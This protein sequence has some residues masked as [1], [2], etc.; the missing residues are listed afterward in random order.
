MS[1]DLLNTFDIAGR[2]SFSTAVHIYVGK[3]CGS[4]TTILWFRS[5]SWLSRW[6]S[7]HLS[8]FPHPI[9]ILSQYFQANSTWISVSSSYRSA[10]QLM[11]PQNERTTR[12]SKKLMLHTYLSFCHLV[13]Y[14]WIN[15]NYS[16]FADTVIHSLYKLIAY[17]RTA[18]PFRAAS[19]KRPRKKPRNLDEF[20]TIAWQRLK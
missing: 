16:H 14:K 2:N 5:L 12:E 18:W 15:L 3:N 17:A 6:V 4:G 7:I 19:E 20:K 13:L 11:Q 9:S 10:D 8:Q 1:Y